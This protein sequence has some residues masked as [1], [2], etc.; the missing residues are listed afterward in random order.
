MF[1]LLFR[2]LFRSLSSL[3]VLLS[4]GSFSGSLGQNKRKKKKKK[5]RGEGGGWRKRNKLFFFSFPTFHFPHFPSPLSPPPLFFLLSFSLSFFLPFF[6]CPIYANSFG[7]Q[8]QIRR[9]PLLLLFAALPTRCKRSTFR[10]KVAQQDFFSPQCVSGFEKEFGQTF[11]DLFLFSCLVGVFL[12][13]AGEKQGMG[14]VW[15][16][17]CLT[18]RGFFPP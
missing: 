4:F 15:A 17:A 8:W 2:H 5:K 3:F 6:I 11:L 10:P 18:L 16:S 1:H 14:G 13:F 7:K 9:P 12:P